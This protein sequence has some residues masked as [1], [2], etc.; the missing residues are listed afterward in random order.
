VCVDRDEAVPALACGNTAVVVRYAYGDCLVRLGYRHDDT[1]LLA[2]GVFDVVG[3]L[4]AEKR[5][6]SNRLRRRKIS[7]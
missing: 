7:A 4:V 5:V 6:R 2:V 1:R 3:R